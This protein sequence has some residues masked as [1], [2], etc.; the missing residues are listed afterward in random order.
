M[1][2]RIENFKEFFRLRKNLAQICVQLNGGDTRSSNVL[3]RFN[4]E[5]RRRTRIIGIFPNAESCERLLTARCQE[6]SEQWE[7]KVYLKFE[8][9]E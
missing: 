2:T 5:L 7:Q 1:I 6:I 8:N 9:E 4:R 3:E